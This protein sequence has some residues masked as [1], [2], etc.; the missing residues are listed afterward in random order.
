[1]AAPRFTFDQRKAATPR[2]PC[3]FCGASKWCIGTREGAWRC[4][5]A[6]RGV[7]VQEPSG[8]R[9][10]RRD[11]EGGTWLVPVDAKG[12]PTIDVPSPEQ[13]R[14]AEA[15]A[16]QKAAEKLARAYTL[17]RTAL[18]PKTGGNV[19]PVEAYLAS[20]K[21]T[22]R[23]PAAIGFAPR[24]PLWVVDDEDGD[25]GRFEDR[26]AMVA[27][28]GHWPG[29]RWD[30]ATAGRSGMAFAGLHVTFLERGGSGWGRMPGAGRRYMGSC[31]GVVQVG[32]DLSRG[33]LCLGEGLETCMHVA[34]ATGLATWAALDA[35]RLQRL[36]LPYGLLRP[37]GGPIHTVIVLV[38]LDTW[39][40]TDKNGKAAWAWPAGQHHAPLAVNN[41]AA[42]AVTTGGAGGR[43]HVYARW[44]TARLLPG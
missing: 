33:V 31:K 38:D 14:A 10:L 26:P 28:V 42:Q 44:P 36:A 30:A 9:I 12:V 7:L 34:Q 24:A 15:E 5:G 19:E 22:L 13:Q 18:R 16:A 27:A 23:L 2:R 20:R 39:K 41:I 40:R 17:W 1:M 37:Q 6:E 35:G 8:W 4:M 32:G 21:I 3:P 43:L 25:K 29:G 11:K